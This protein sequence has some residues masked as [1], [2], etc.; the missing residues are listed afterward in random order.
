LTDCLQSNATWYNNIEYDNGGLLNTYFYGTTVWNT[1][2]VSTYQ[3][4]AISCNAILSDSHYDEQ[5]LYRVE[6]EPPNEDYGSRGY[7]KWFID[8]KLI[9]GIYGESLQEA[10]GTEIPSEP[11]YLLMNTAVS[12]DWGFPD[13]YYL[14]CKLKCWT[15]ADPRCRVCALPEGYC[16]NFPASF[17]IDYVRVYQAEQEPNHI[18]D[19]S[20]KSRP[21][22]SFIEANLARYMSKGETRPLQR[23]KEGGG[24]CDNVNECGGQERGTCSSS[25]LC[26][27]VIGWIGPHCLAH[28]PFYNTGDSEF[29]ISRKFEWTALNLEQNPIRLTLIRLFSP[30]QDLPRISYWNEPFSMQ[31][32]FSCFVYDVA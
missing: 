30:E 6:W 25:G 19:C 11:M 2:N 13:A 9:T 3:S 26:T 31:H 27:C 21:T 24:S 12:K 32:H 14:N 18:L 15:C 5:H 28:S 29:P 8:G 4:D 1:P 16:E 17:E 7:L 23:I 22:E 20:P 10:S